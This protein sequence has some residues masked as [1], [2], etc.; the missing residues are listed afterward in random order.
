M[1]DF[2]FVYKDY[3]D[4]NRAYIAHGKKD[5]TAIVD[6]K[7]IE[8]YVLGEKIISNKVINLML[9]LN[10]VRNH[11]NSVVEYNVLIFSLAVYPYTVYYDKDNDGLVVY[12]NKPENYDL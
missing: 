2:Y 4:R 3:D 6:Y 7:F 8:K 11:I 5:Y 10:D 12:G 1:N 9:D